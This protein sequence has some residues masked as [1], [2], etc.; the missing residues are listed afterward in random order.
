M[1]VQ[2]LIYVTGH[3]NP[4]TDSIVSAIAYAALM[5]ALGDRRYTAA[6]LGT[7]SDETAHI[8]ERFGFPAPERIYNVFTQ[9]KDL[10]FERPPVLLAV[11]D[12]DIVE[13]ASNVKIKDNNV[14]L[15][16][17]LSRKKQVAQ[18]LSLLWG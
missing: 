3:K 16:G 13:E 11:G 9:V 7:L 6:R 17:V 10:N 4:D 18:A 15:P 5:N 8:P 12:V 14:F 1:D 2:N